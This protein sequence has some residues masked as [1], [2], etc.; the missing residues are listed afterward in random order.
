MP[1]VGPLGPEWYR[2]SYGP[3]AQLVAH[4]HDTQGVVGS[5]PARPTKN[6]PGQVAQL[7]RDVVLSA[8]PPHQKGEV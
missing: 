5:S 6:V 8:V 7:A 1:G 4:L 3:L 2:Q